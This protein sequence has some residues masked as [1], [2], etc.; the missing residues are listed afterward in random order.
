MGYLAESLLLTLQRL[1]YRIHYIC[2]KR[3]GK[4]NSSNEV[5]LIKNKKAKKERKK[6]T[7]FHLF[8]PNP[9]IPNH[10]QGHVPCVLQLNHS[11]H[12]DFDLYHLSFFRVN[13][14]HILF[15]CLENL[16]LGNYGST[17]SGL[18]LFLFGRDL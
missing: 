3:K 6:C 4:D 16:V 9:T 2:F 5:K 11:L 8:R 10:Q 13:F 17:F 12:T 14:L 1:P 18:K 15:G 7:W